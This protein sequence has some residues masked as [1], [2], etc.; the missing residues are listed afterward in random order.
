M[1][2]PFART[3][4]SRAIFE[5]TALPV[6]DTSA[7]MALLRKAHTVFPESTKIAAELGNRLF[8]TGQGVEARNYFD[9]ACGQKLAADLCKDDGLLDGIPFQWQFSHYIRQ[10]L[11]P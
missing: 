10:V 1:E 3:E 5:I 2:H 11:S 8:A 6:R 4:L 9:Y 7:A